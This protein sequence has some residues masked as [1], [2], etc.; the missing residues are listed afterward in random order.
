M[1]RCPA[2]VS[3][4]LVSVLLVVPSPID[5]SAIVI[6]G[7]LITLERGRHLRLQVLLIEAN[8]K[9][10]LPVLNKGPRNALEGLAW[11]LGPYPCIP[12]VHAP[13]GIFEWSGEREL[14]A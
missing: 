8:E 4:A 2:I 5:E 9:L 7:T 1:S 13:H 3:G 12:G 14:R 10:F 6:L 11:K